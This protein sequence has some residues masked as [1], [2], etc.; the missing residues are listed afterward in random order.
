VRAVDPLVDLEQVPSTL[1]LVELTG[2]ELASTD[3]VIMVTD[4]DAFDVEL[5][6]AMA[7]LVLDTRRSL[8]MGP[9][10]EHL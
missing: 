8:P 10:V 4:H 6:A 2:E 1:Q 3:L 5:V 9:N 7:P